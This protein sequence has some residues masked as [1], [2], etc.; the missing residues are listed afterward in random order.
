MKLL[1][2][3]SDHIVLEYDDLTIF[4]EL[5]IDWFSTGHY[6][7]PKAPIGD[8]GGVERA[9][10]DKEP[11]FDLIEEFQRGCPGK[12]IHGQ[13]IVKKEFVDKFDIVLVSHCCP[14][15]YGILANWEALKHK[16]VVW[17]TYCQQQ[18]EIERDMH[19]LISQGLKVIRVSAKE[20]NIRHSLPMTRVIRAYV[21]SNHYFGWTGEE[22]HVL[23]FNNFFARRA[24]ISNTNEYLHVVKDIPHKLFGGASDN[25]PEVLGHLSWEDQKIAYRKAGAYFALGSKPAALTFNMVEAMLTGTPTVTWGK[26]LGNWWGTAWQG[27]YEAADLIQNG[28][29]GFASDNLKELNAFIK[30]LLINEQLAKTI[31][32]NGRKTVL[33]EFDKEKVKRDWK[34]FLEG[35]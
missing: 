27:T 9:P 35:L 34:E 6:L 23:T 8:P 30:E 29:N 24:L 20:Q 16:P 3:S 25:H 22:K 31:S 26:T 33:A 11:N 7:N 12:Q 2:I 13:T 17:R 5:G 19:P 15:P 1:Y 14:W 32:E 18:S 28:V 10:I 21:D 4:T